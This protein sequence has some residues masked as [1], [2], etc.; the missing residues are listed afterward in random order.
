MSMSDSAIMHKSRCAKRIEVV[1]IRCFLMRQKA[2]TTTDFDQGW[3]RRH[4]CCSALLSKV[5]MADAN[6][7]AGAHRSSTS[8]KTAGAVA[9]TSISLSPP[10][11][12]VPGRGR[13]VATGPGVASVE[14][15]DGQ[16]LAGRSMTAPL[17]SVL[18]L[19]FWPRP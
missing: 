17:C 9:T 15:E 16:T 18:G 10:D 11:A 4:Q 5:R 6:A 7:R 19:V 8:S 14:T 3:H 2:L 1:D 13:D 12:L